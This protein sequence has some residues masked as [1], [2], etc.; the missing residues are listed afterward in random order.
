MGSTSTRRQPETAGQARHGRVLEPDKDHTILGR[1]L[2]DLF[3]GLMRGPG[4]TRWI[5]RLCNTGACGRYTGNCPV[6]R[7]LKSQQLHG[8]HQLRERAIVMR[9]RPLLSS[10]T[11]GW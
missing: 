3:V 9:W 4:A 11:Y 7:A 6:G 8:E 2:D 5:C 1:L 10:V